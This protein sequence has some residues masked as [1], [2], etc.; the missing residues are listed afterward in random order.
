MRRIAVIDQSRQFF[1]VGGIIATQPGGEEDGK[2]RLLL[3]REH[4]NLLF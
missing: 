4:G 1:A 3:F 2:F